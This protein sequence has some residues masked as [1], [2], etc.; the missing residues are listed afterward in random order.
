MSEKRPTLYVKSLN[1]THIGTYIG[2][3]TRDFETF[4]L[5]FPLYIVISSPFAFEDLPITTNYEL[6]DDL[7][8]NF[9]RITYS[10]TAVNL[11]FK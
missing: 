1:S 8:L 3:Y 7:Q 10:A 2:T 9:R 6:F 11:L 5:F 4:N